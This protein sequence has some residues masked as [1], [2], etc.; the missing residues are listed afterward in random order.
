MP[1][2]EERNSAQDQSCTLKKQRQDQS[3]REL[4]AEFQSTC[5]CVCMPFRA[6]VRLGLPLLYPELPEVKRICA[7]FFLRCVDTLNGFSATFCA[8][9]ELPSPKGR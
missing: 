1:A 3:V 4:S 2:T 5:G 8:S 6:K 7:P 9:I